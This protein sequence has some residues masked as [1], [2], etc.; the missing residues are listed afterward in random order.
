M[1]D[2]HAFTGGGAGGG[3]PERRRQE[4][5]PLFGVTERESVLAYIRRAP[6]R[7]QDGTATWSLTT[8]QRSLRPELP[9]LSTL[10]TDTL[11]GVLHGAGLSWQKSRTWCQTGQARRV[12][13]GRDGTAEAVDVTGPDAEAK[14]LIEDARR[15]GTSLGLAVWNQDEAGPYQTVP[16]PGAGWQP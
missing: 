8:L 5:A 2:G 3:P 9:T 10:S 12:R 4:P 13:R 15:L 7:G 1:A 11:W 16:Q 6:D 14:K